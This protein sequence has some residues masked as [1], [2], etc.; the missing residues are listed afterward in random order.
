MTKE[1]V[2]EIDFL[3][4]FAA[5]SVVFFHYAFRGAAADELS[6]LAFPVLAPFAQYGYLGVELFFMISGF[7]ILMTAS[8]G[9]LRGF[10]ISR[11]VRLYPAFWAC[12][13]IT[14]CIALIVDLPQFQ[15][16][17]KQFLINLL[18]VNEFIGV[19]SI[20]SAY[21][22]LFVEM[23][24]YAMVA[25]I[26]VIGRIHQVELWLVLWLGCSALNQVL[27]N[28]RLEYYL[29]TNYSAFFIAGASFY[30]IWSLGLSTRRLVLLL[31][32]WV[33][34]IHQ[35]LAALPGFA[36]H[37]QV[38]LNQMVVA[39]VVTGFFVLMGLI[40]LRKTGKFGRYTWGMAG[41]VTYPLYLLHQ[42]LGYMAFNLA[43]S[44]WN[45][46]VVLVLTTLAMIAAA[47]MV[48]QLMEGR[49]ARAFK[50]LLNQILDSLPGLKSGRAA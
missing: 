7:V 44:S 9:S 19:P 25:V 2:N 49:F 38:V 24:F 45:P 42:N 3:R 37:Y 29:V 39:A 40:A 43:D 27:H 8:G 33:L 28:G 30:L 17:I 31:L 11:M 32:S 26:L 35:A 47:Y 18:M 23:K 41:A 5:L 36:K 34:S 12:C 50:R 13:L 46:Y 1:R 10:A 22:S 16:N 15:V 6:P 14:F 20:D 48:H 4:F 21:W